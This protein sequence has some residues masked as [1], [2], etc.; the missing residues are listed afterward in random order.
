MGGVRA[1]NGCGLKLVAA[2]ALD[3]SLIPRTHGQQCMAACNSSFEFPVF[4]RRMYVCANTHI[5][6]HPYAYT[7]EFIHIDKNKSS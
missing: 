6:T 4:Y 2:G 5:H 1:G 7:Y 3:C